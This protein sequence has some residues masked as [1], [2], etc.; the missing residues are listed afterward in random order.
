MTENIKSPQNDDFID[1]S[2]IINVL[3]DQWRLFIVI[4][5]GALIVGTIAY[6]LVPPRWQAEATLRVGEIASASP[7]ESTSDTELIEPVGEAIARMYLAQFQ[8]TVISSPTL[9]GLEQGEIGLFKRTFEAEPVKGTY[10]IHV[11]VSGNSPQTARKML[12]AVIETLFLA[13]QVKMK[14]AIQQVQDRIKSLNGRIALKQKSL[15]QLKQILGEKL[16]GNTIRALDLLDRQ[17]TDIQQL[18]DQRSAMESMLHPPQTFNTTV[19]DA[20]RAGRKPYFPRLSMFL[21]ASVLVGGLL[22][23]LTS[24]CCYRKKRQLPA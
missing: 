12:E 15:G 17:Q 19:V 24:L 11:S 3:K 5:L 8:D 16:T 21:I 23:F 7:G 22:G 18:M 10:F 6:S 20:V 14:L 1:L 4:L 13:H 2:L 9:R